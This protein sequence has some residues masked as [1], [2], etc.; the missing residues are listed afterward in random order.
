MGFMGHPFFICPSLELS[1]SFGFCFPMGAAWSRYPHPLL[2]CGL[3]REVV[4]GGESGEDK[5]P[6]TAGRAG[7]RAPSLVA[8]G[9]ARIPTHRGRETCMWPGLT[10]HLLCD[11]A[12]V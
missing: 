9:P 3:D 8:Q 2:H 12:Q 10:A 11:Q 5:L 6:H 7:H 1:S 4:E